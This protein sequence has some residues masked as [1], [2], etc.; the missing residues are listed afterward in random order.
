MLVDME[1]RLAPR[2]LHLFRGRS[3]PARPP[4]ESHEA[5]AMTTADKFPPLPDRES[6]GDI[7]PTIII[8]TR[9]QTPLAF[10]RLPSRTGTLTQGDYS[11]AGLEAD[12]AIERKSIPDLVG[13]LTAGRERFMREVDRLRGCPFA[14]LL[15][16]GAEADLVAGRYRSNANPKA[17]IN[18]LHAIE[19]RGLLVVFAATP[20]EAAALVECWAWWRAR[21]VL[22][23]GNEILKQ[24]PTHQN[25]DY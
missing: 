16:V 11:A 1:P 19:S 5:V 22:Q 14:R 20:E 23:C 7:L 3:D 25:H 8:D 4:Q 2:L 13:S 12:F 21:A 6:A 10:P 24:N 17:I 15:I 18:S 9:E